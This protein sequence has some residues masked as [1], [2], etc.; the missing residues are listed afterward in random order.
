M[1][2][3]SRREFGRIFIAGAPFAAI[4]GSARTLAL[5]PVELGVSTLS[6]SDLPR[7]EGRENVDEVIRALKAAGAA[8]AELALS[9][10]EPAPPSTA[11]FVGGT[12]A[13][14]RTVT[15]TPEQVA[16]IKAH[17][18]HVVR[19]WRSR[20]EPR[21]FHETRDKFAAANVRVISCSLAY[22][23]SF[24]DEEIEATFRQVKALGV[25]T[26]SS[27]M[28]MATARR[29]VP[30]AERHGVT[31][32]IHNQAEGNA[33]GA[34]A[35]AGLA[36]ALALSAKYSVKLDIG[37]VTA[38]NGDAVAELNRHESRVA[39]VLVRD[40]LRNGGKSQHFGEG[41][42]P[43]PA[44]LERMKASTLEIPGV[45]E[46]DYVGLHSSVEEV[47]AALRYVT[48]AVGQ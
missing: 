10:V 23:D 28:T 5:A 39:Y 1:T 22:D 43:I 4:A 12:A 31:V 24:T 2:A 21:Y 34:I 15:F 11:S 46:Y 44:V 38:S 42:T 33:A 8:R 19:D 47:T 6:F 48:H 26:I 25:A 27:P 7:V 14:P 3:F 40:R 9:N 32:A 20:T 16:H 17:A 35:A 13:Y 18:R 29:I 30:F 45:V 37:N 36:E 41:D